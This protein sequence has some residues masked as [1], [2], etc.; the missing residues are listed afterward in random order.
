MAEIVENTKMS[1]LRLR[2][3]DHAVSVEA[4]D[5]S[6]LL[7]M[8]DTY[9]G[10]KPIYVP[11]GTYEMVYGD[12]I[13]IDTD[14]TH[15]I[16]DPY[17]IIRLTGSYASTGYVFKFDDGSGR[18]N[19]CLIEGGWLQGTTTDTTKKKAFYI[20]GSLNVTFRDMHFST[21]SDLFY[22]DSSAS[23]RAN[24]RVRME[25]LYAY[26]TYGYLVYNTGV[27]FGAITARTFHHTWNGADWRTGSAGFFS[28]GTDSGVTLD[29]IT[30]DHTDLAGLNLTGNGY[31]V[32]NS[33]FESAGYNAGG[34]ALDNI[35]YGEEIY[36]SKCLFNACYG[37]GLQAGG[38]SAKNNNKFIASTF[39]TNSLSEAAGA[40]THDG[41]ALVKLLNSSVLGCVG[42]DTQASK[43]QRYGFSMDADSDDIIYLGNNAESNQTAGFKNFG[44]GTLKPAAWDD[45]ND[46]TIG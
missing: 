43:T 11:R 10:V 15:I 14:G 28:D 46:G 13:T 24:R 4:D 38:A 22:F 21:L 8:I 25:D 32:V 30:T 45:L 42:R 33:R 20:E 2:Q 37:H 12:D 41:L 6:D 16:M 9:Q 34:T 17:A 39:K 31:R 29:D 18:V 44:A 23:A 27:N 26:D 3:M 40:G 7:D 1:P 5:K 35:V 19:D 36:I